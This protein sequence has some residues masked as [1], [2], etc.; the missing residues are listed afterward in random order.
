MAQRIMQTGYLYYV[1]TCNQD[2]TEGEN[3]TKYLVFIWRQSE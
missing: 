1:E 3:K 2:A